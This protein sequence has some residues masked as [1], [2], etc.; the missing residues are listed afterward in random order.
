MT[1]CNT[2]KYKFEVRVKSSNGIINI[3][4]KYYDF[5]IQQHD[6]IIAC[7]YITW[8]ILMTLSFIDKSQEH[9]SIYY[10]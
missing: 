9:Y 8:S 7:I 2:V 10:V 6:N 5:L 1:L 4:R 3:Q